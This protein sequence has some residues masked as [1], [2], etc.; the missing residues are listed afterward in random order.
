MTLAKIK[1]KRKGMFSSNLELNIKP[2]GLSPSDFKDHGS[3]FLARY[4]GPD[5]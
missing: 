3:W 5:S 1:V 4:V 2:I